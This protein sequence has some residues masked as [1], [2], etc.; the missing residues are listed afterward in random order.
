VKRGLLL[1]FDRIAVEIYWGRVFI[2]C[3]HMKLLL[4]FSAVKGSI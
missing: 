2:R 1:G 3:W 4:K